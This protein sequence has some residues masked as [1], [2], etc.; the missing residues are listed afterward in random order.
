[1]AKY[2]YL[3]TYLR[4]YLR[5]TMLRKFTGGFSHFTIGYML[6]YCDIKT[7]NIATNC[8]SNISFF[9]HAHFPFEIVNNIY[10]VT[11]DIFLHISQIWPFDVLKLSVVFKHI[12]H[13][14][15]RLS[16]HV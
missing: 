8:F 5:K 14:F 6:V 13:I 10:S 12:W 1:M 7:F 11:I 3:P 9:L 4:T 2:T 15:L 16:M